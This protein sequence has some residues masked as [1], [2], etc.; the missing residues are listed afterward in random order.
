[1]AET[2]KIVLLGAPGV[3]KTCIRT[4]LA[5]RPFNEHYMSTVGADCSVIT[6]PR[7]DK[8]LEIWDIAGQDI[9]ATNSLVPIYLKETNG[10][11]IV[12]DPGAFNEW[13]VQIQKYKQIAETHA[14][15]AQIFYVVNKCDDEHQD[16]AA[17]I[18]A[19]KKAHGNATKANIS[20]FYSAKTSARREDL[21][22]AM[23]STV[24]LDLTATSKLK[25]KIN[26]DP[27]VKENG[28]AP[29]LTG[30]RAFG[31]L[32]LFAALGTTFL[33][34]GG[35][36]GGVE[37]IWSNIGEFFSAIQS[38]VDLGA[39]VLTAADWG[40]GVLVASIL[41]AAVITGGS[42]LIDY[43]R[44][45]GDEP[46]SKVHDG[47]KGYQRQ[48]DLTQKTN[49]PRNPSQEDLLNAAPPRNLN[50]PPAQGLNQCPR[51]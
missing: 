43:Y 19:I 15:N 51:Q 13:P 25:D 46:G 1:M 10:I 49:L 29:Y 33:A 28:P 9:Q 26:Q 11:G 34:L 23:A 36:T 48:G 7:T 38:A 37:H 17:Q 50:V 6:V 3:G 27:A 31:F 8:K 44:K 35:V 45:T 2:K 32:V 18:Q 42:M 5:E 22:W 14:P 47:E 30:P 21:L 16:N 20:P 4:T 40:I 24:G 39:G 12:L 41:L